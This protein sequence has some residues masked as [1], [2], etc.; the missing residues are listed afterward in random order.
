MLDNIG[1]DLWAK[2]YDKS[3]EKSNDEYSYPFAG[4]YE[5]LKIIYETVC[6]QKKDGY[7][8]DVGFGTGTLTEKF[9]QNGYSVTGIDFS[10]KMIEAANLKMPNANLIQHDFSTGYPSALKEKTFDFIISTYAIHHLSTQQ[11]INFIQQL[12]KHLNPNGLLLIGDVGFSTKK[13]L[14]SCRQYYK[15]TWDEDEIYITEEELHPYF[16]NMVFSKVSFCSGIFIFP[17]A[18]LYKI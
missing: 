8:L 12:L 11:K 16:P 1:F 17:T 2:Y 7:I 13:E 6:E 15:D 10:Q 18:N 5:I 14:E 4:Y 3:T 9:Y